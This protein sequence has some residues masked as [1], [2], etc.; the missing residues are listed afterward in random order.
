M[1]RW[2]VVILLAMSTFPVCAQEQAKPIIRTAL[3]Q[4]TAVPGQPVTLRLTVLVPTWMPK[5]PVLPAY[6]LPNLMVRLPPRS[7]H[8]VSERVD[9]ETW[10]GIT[11]VYRLHPLVEGIV[12]IAPQ[13]VILHYADPKTRKPVSVELPTP[14]FTITGVIPENG[15]GLDPFIAATALRIEQVIEG[16][17]ADLEPGD[18]VKRQLS[19]HIEGASPMMVPPLM[20]AEEMHG[21]AIYGADPVLEEKADGAILSGSRSEVITYVAES[22]GRFS[23]P[24]VSV[25]WYNQAEDRIET[26]EVDGVDLTVRGPPSEVEPNR[27]WRTDLDQWALPGFL[28]VLLALAFWRLRQPI[29]MWRRRRSSDYVASEKFALRQAQRALD[30]HQLSPALGATAKW[31]NRRNAGRYP[32][33]ESLK[34]PL[35]HI[36]AALYGRQRPDQKASM[37]T[38]ETAIKALRKLAWTR[39]R[40]IM[41]R[42]GTF[43]PP[44]NPTRSDITR[45]NDY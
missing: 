13:Q 26:A 6:D 10:S 22:G 45:R 38:W 35:Q 1:I 8:P 39:Q 21:L 42:D 29:A 4:A 41:H 3:D 23:L 9:G 16:N 7:T 11:R 24:P 44:L 2:T 34:V 31:W 37:K 25:H 40:S 14:A 28:V 18:V 30:G 32:I 5:P 27:D 36:G 33:P 43:L 19:V 17:P 20:S 15:A 12:R